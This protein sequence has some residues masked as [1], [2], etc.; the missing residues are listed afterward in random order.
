MGE[1]RLQ[2][3][4]SLQ[5]NQLRT[6]VMEMDIEVMGNHDRNSNQ[7]RDKSKKAVKLPEIK[8]VQSELQVE[9]PRFHHCE[10][11]EQEIDEP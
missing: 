7:R 3:S 6:E 9:S 10:V 1:E 4:W 11:P 2:W 8:E 5:L